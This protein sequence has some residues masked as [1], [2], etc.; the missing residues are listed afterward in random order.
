MTIDDWGNH[1]ESFSSRRMAAQYSSLASVWR[2]RRPSEGICNGGKFG[3]KALRALT[4]WVWTKFHGWGF[5]LRRSKRELVWDESLNEICQVI[6]Q[7]KEWLD[8]FYITELIWKLQNF[9]WNVGLQL[10]LPIGNRHAKKI[11]RG[12]S[13]NHFLFLITWLHIFVRW[14]ENLSEAADEMTHQTKRVV[15]HQC[16]WVHWIEAVEKSGS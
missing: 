4:Q 2:I 6:N 10:V 12:L 16:R 5:F 7:S 14:H 9:L 8:L 1:L 13:E 3:V 11:N 15:C